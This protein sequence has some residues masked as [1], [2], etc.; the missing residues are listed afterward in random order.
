MDY[1]PGPHN[2]ISGA[3]YRSQSFQLVNYA[4]GQLL[5]Q[6]EATV[7][8]LTEF[9]SGDWTWTPG[10]T[11]VNDFRMGYSFL[12]NQTIPGDSNLKPS[13]PWPNGYGINTGVVRIRFMAGYRNRY[14]QLYRLFGCRQANGYPRAGRYRDFVDN[15]SHLHGKHCFKFGGSNLWTAFMT[16]TITIRPTV[17]LNSEESKTS[18]V[19]QQFLLGKPASGTIL[20]GNPTCS[21]ETTPSQASSKMIGA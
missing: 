5:P 8:Q 13:D 4:N 6:W 2:H 18:T 12:Q 17:R 11:L 3:F 1:I 7:P 9:M 15:V 16:R 19:L 20:I 10:S 21:R 14:L